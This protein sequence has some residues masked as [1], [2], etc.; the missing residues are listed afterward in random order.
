[1]NA[2]GFRDVLAAALRGWAGH[3]QVLRDLDAALG[4]GDLGITV[5]AGSV[6][7]ADALEASHATGLGDML[8][9]AAQAFATANPSTF[10]ALLGG[11]ALAGAKVLPAAEDYTVA[12]AL[13]FGRAAVQSIQARG[14]AELGDKTVLDALVPSLEVLESPAGSATEVCA[15]MAA[16]AHDRV[17]QTAGWESKRGRAGWL[18]ERSVGQPDAGSSAYALLLDELASQFE[19]RS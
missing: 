13:A 1:M 2:A 3:E 8:R 4:D 17:R 16:V 5:R 15:A 9:A 6:A 19:A 12:D 14:K 11:G 7:A 18:G 10:A